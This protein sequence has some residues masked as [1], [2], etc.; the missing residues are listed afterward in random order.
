MIPQNGSIDLKKRSKSSSDVAQTTEVLRPLRDAGIFGSTLRSDVL[1]LI[2][3]LERTYPRELA[4]ILERPISM[5]QRALEDL[6]RASVIVT[7]LMG[8]QREVRLNPDFVVAKELY[9]LLEALLERDRRYRD[10]LRLAARR[11]PRRAGKA[12]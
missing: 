10:R 6:E 2:A 1:V 4:R 8:N 11:R 9:E 3:G 7:R 12:V 5:V